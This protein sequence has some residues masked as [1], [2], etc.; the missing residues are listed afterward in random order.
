[1]M[2]HHPV[3]DHCC[4]GRLDK[5]AVLEARRLE[6]DVVTL[7][8]A[9]FAR[10]IHHGRILAVNRRRLAIGIGRIVPGIE[11]LDL[12]AAHQ[13]NAAIGAPLSRAARNRWRGPLDMI[14]RVAEFLPGED[15]ARSAYDF[16]VAVLDLPTWRL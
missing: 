15:L 5:L 10:C 7:P 12:V 14:L 6:D 11:N 8:L 4:I 16:H 1:M 2:D 13:K 9:R 3:M